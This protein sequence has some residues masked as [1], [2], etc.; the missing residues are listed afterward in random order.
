M[1]LLFYL[2]SR[3]GEQHPSTGQVMPSSCENAIIT[4]GLNNSKKH[5]QVLLLATQKS[6]QLNNTTI[7]TTT[8]TTA[9]ATAEKYFR[10]IG[11]DVWAKTCPRVTN[12]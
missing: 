5:L 4:Q 9:T 3:K 8:S 12:M 2:L 11:G 7:V 10:T 6:S 1:S